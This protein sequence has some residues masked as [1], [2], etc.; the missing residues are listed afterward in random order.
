MDNYTPPPI[1]SVISVENT[2]DYA[3]EVRDF[4]ASVVGWSV[5]PLSMGDY[6]DY[7]MKSVDDSWVAGICYRRGSNADLPGGWIPC[8]RVASVE[9][10]IA[11]AIARGGKQVGAT[12]DQGSGSRY[13]VIEDMYG[14]KISVI[15]FSEDT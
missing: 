8:V 7:V 15:D 12:R 4:Y 13:A 1:G 9:N 5:E 11:E 14:S 10:A 2:T 6:D 3:D